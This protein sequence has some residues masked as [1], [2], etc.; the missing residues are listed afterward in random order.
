M[1]LVSPGVHRE[2]VVVTT[3][4]LTI[5]G[6]DRNAVILDGEFRRA[7]GI[8]VLEADGVTIQNMTARS[9]C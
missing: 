4:Y 3:P 5:R 8:Q 1:V 9:F 7:N 6:T 2:S